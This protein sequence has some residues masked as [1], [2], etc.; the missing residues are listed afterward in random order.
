MLPKCV[1][2]LHGLLVA[3]STPGPSLLHLFVK[4]S[5]CTSLQNADGL[6]FTVQMNLWILLFLIHKDIHFS[7]V[8]KGEK[9]FFSLKVT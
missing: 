1:V 3:S 4:F 7:L 9:D 8:D 5:H 2:E 6:M